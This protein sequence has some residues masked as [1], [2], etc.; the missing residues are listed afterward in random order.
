VANYRV[1]FFQQIADVDGNLALAS[2]LNGNVADTITVAQLV[3]NTN[4]FGTAL[5]AATNGKA[6]RWSFEVLVGEAQ[7]I[8]GS[9]PPTDATY[10]SVTDGARLNF[11][12]SM[13][14]R[15]S[16]VV[17]APTEATFLA[18]PQRDYVD[19]AGD[20]AA[21]I[22]WMQAHSLDTGGQAFN[23]YQGGIKVGRGARRRR[24]PKAGLS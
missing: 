5:L 20:A 9:T 7:L 19:P 11:S 23:L 15:T 8:P 4:G 12:N 6:V 21:L 14:S 10:P 17:P 13:G 16:V 22:A 2:Y 1:R 24:P 18:A 3:T